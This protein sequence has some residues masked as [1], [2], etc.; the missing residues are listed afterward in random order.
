[1]CHYQR[2][3]FLKTFVFSYLYLYK[4]S[5]EFQAQAAYTLIHFARSNR[6]SWL[7]QSS[8]C[9]GRDETWSEF[10]PSQL[11]SVGSPDWKAKGKLTQADLKEAIYMK[12][13]ELM[14]EGKFFEDAAEVGK[15]LKKHWLQP[16]ESFKYEKIAEMHSRLEKIYANIAVENRVPPKYYRVS[17]WGRGHPTFL[18]VC[19]YTK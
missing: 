2:Q 15:E 4:H 1:M 10:L 14:D 8:N 17:F 18:Q 9:S 11:Q 6:L 7:N 19:P 12:A 5:P 13:F 16:S 3:R